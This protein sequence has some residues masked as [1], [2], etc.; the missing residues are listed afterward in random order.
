M[1]LI[2]TA[3]SLFMSFF[4]MLLLCQKRQLCFA[5][6]ENKLT[7]NQEVS[8]SVGLP[9]LLSYYDYQVTVLAES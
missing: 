5:K 3:K 1:L 8:V 4:H 7:I 6:L 2:E 9:Q